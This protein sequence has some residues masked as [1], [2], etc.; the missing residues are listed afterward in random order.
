M[1]QSYVPPDKVLEKY[2]DLIVRFG[3][4]TRDGKTLKKG[5]VVQYVVPE[6][7]KPLYFHLQRA[8]LRAGYNPLGVFLPSNTEEYNF[9]K[10]FFDLATAA[11]IDFFA[12]H[13]NRGLIDQ[14]DGSIFI[15][16]D[17]NPHSLLEVDPKKVLRRSLA[18]RQ[19][20]DWRFQKINA[21]KLCWTLALYGTDAAAK[22]AGM[23]LKQFWNQIINACYLN[24]DN[25]VQ[26]W[27][28]LNNSVQKTAA[29]LTALQIKSLHFSGKDL[30]LE[31]GIGKNRQWRAG[32][33]NNIPSYEIFT[34][35]NSFEVNGWARFNQPHYR[36]GKKIEGIELW[37]KDGVVIKSD[38]TKNHEL[39]KAM[40]KTPGGNRL[41]EV[42]LTDAKHS[43]ITKFMAETLYD[44]NIGGKF[45]NTHIALGSAYR[46]CFL[47]KTNAETDE[48]WETLGFNNSVVHSDIIS[49]TD[50]T[51][52]AT[53]Y[54]GSQK[55][56]YQKGSFVI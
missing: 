1:Q 26:V 20:K 52:T 28:Q 56:I 29:K 45:G 50:R 43:R 8:I 15:I 13:F 25:P 48:E 49:T 54:D 18:S 14:I 30:D 42:S 5:A 9:D 34:T 7:A 40:L 46:D 41:G 31:I 6:V 22:E 4:Q 47:G 10:S 23:T 35:P 37:F 3:L 53:L 11:Q 33:G 44:E 16:A 38:A 51:V 19:G 32:G 2:A 21:G 39:L 36:Y 17:T 12:E 55:I 24:E 27:K